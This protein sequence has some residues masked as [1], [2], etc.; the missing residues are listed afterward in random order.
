MVRLLG[1]I[2]LGTAGVFWLITRPVSLPD[3]ALAGLTGRTDQGERVFLAA[4]CGSCHMA[5]DATG[6]ARLV[7]AGGQRFPSDFGTFVAPNISPHPEAGIGAW[8]DPEIANA[9]LRGVSPEGAH[10]FPAFP[11][12]AYQRMEMQDMADL[13]AYLRTLPESDAPSAPHEVGFPFSVRRLVGGWKWLFAA[14]D[15]VLQD[16]ADAEIARGRYLVEAL[17]H[18]GEC[19]TPRGPL[20]ELA[21]DAWLTGAPVPGKDRGRVPGIDPASLDWSEGDIVEYLTSGFTP[22][23]DTAGGHMVEVIA[24]FAQLPESDRRAVAAYLKALP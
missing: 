1:L 14:P 13:I 4:G 21:R 2:I 16:P 7:L 17:A 22:E 24:N 15:W 12:T 18:C 6:A 11:Y 3:D 10:Y 20:G 8:S 5:P 9:V 19:H 23:F